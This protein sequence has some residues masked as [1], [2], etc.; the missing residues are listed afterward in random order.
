MSSI[1]CVFRSGV[2]GLMVDSGIRFKMLST[3]V[4]LAIILQ[5]EHIVKKK[6][7]KTYSTVWNMS[8]TIN[9]NREALFDVPER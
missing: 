5:L 7:A 3:C 6:T 9:G 4:G 8:Y 1:V 2:G